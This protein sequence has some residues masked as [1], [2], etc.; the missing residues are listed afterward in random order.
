MHPIHNATASTDIPHA[1]GTDNTSED[2]YT[3]RST[4]FLA[5]LQDGGLKCLITTPRALD[6]ARKALSLQ[7]LVL[8]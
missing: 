7:D 5:S 2:T 8:Q 1:T 4:P 3:R 6:E